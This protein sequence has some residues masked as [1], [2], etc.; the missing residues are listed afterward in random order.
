MLSSSHP[1][2]CQNATYDVPI[3]DP[4]G[5]F[6]NQGIVDLLSLPVERLVEASW[7]DTL[8]NFNWC[9]VPRSGEDA[10]LFAAIAV[11][12]S[13]VVFGRFSTLLILFLGKRKDLFSALQPLNAAFQQ[14]KLPLAFLTA[15]KLTA[16][17]IL[18]QDSSQL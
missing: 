18:L 12:A 2:H 11:A 1:H 14:L 15:C 10:I 7:T 5:P 8:G 3:Q 16:F 4:G 17:I 9:V 13:C 6:L